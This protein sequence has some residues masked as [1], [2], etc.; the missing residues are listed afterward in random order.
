M[1]NKT[2]EIIELLKKQID[3]ENEA[4]KQ[5]SEGESNAT[6]AAVRLVYLDMRLDTW[7]HIKFLEGVMEVLSNA[8]C[9]EWM[10]KVARYTDRV[11]LERMLRHIIAQE[12]SMARISRDAAKLMDDPLGKILIEHLKEDEERHERDLEKIIKL[13]KQLPLQPKK[14]R[15]G[16][17][18]PC[19]ED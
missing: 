7:K 8:P 11:K 10:A 16:S 4:L 6:E 2:T 3:V 5:I 13:M 19:P 17:D 15:L 9:D 12:N 1:A 14:G 18:I